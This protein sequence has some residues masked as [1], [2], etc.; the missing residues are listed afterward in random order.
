MWHNKLRAV[1]A[2]IRWHDILQDAG[3]WGIMKNKI[4]IVR[5]AEV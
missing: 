2:M 5:Q 3:A 4:F 1:T